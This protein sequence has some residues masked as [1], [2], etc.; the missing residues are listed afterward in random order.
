MNRHEYTFLQLHAIFHDVSGRASVN[1]ELIM[2]IV[3]HLDMS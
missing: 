1:M 3:I 2:A